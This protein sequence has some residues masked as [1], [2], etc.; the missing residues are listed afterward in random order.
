MVDTGVFS[1]A[2]SPR[3]RSATADQLTALRGNQLFLAAATV[4]ELRFGALIAE[5]GP[6]R[7]E[8][9]EAAIATATVVPV[10]D[11]YLTAVAEL[12]AACRRVGHPLAD[13]S[14]ASDLWIAARA[15]H[16]DAKL[17]TADRV[18]S[19]APGLVVT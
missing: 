3:R 18:F 2:L 8:R 11:R 16:I 14:H 5:W 7:R 19:G 13:R 17:V 10:T 4:A 1:A 6:S 9:L 15:V 12:R